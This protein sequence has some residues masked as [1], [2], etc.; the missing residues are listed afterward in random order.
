VRE[1]RYPVIGYRYVRFPISGRSTE[2]AC[3]LRPV[4]WSMHVSRWS[5]SMAR[6][7]NWLAGGMARHAKFSAIHR[8]VC[9]AGQGKSEG[10]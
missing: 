3:S 4:D 6:T 10:S 7:N 1:H 8:C 9:C 5:T 2:V